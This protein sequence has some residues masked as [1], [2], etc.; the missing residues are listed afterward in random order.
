MTEEVARVFGVP[1]QVIPFKANAA[2][3][4]PEPGPRHHVC[5]MP[6]RA[7]LEILFPRVEGYR[8]AIRNRITVNWDAVP[9]LFLDP[10]KIPP[11]VEMKASLPG[12]S[13]RPSLSGP[14]RLERVDLN[15][16]RQGRREQ[17]LV[18][19]MAGAL[20]KSYVTNGQSEAPAH[21]LFPQIARIVQRY[22]DTKVIPVKPAEKVDAFL[23]PYYGWA[24]ER[25][26]AAIRPDASAGETPEVPIYETSRGPGSTAEVDYWTSKDV[27]E[28]VTSHLNYVVADTKVWEQSAAYV[29][30]TH[31]RVA[32]FVKNAGLGFAIPY[33]H[34]GQPRDYVPDFTV[35]LEGEPRV[36]LIVETKGY[37][38]LAGVKA[39][40]AERWVAAVNADGQYGEWR[41]AMARK[42]SEVR[43]VLDKA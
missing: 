9:P 31:P 12:N 33:L 40:A 30:D 6:G 10:L 39:A 24:V 32:A 37:D 22:F 20:T 27:R 42:V 28:V 8:Q 15:P 16:Y 34:N 5:A 25:L 26:T 38:E 13:G 43:D 17:A 35:R 11:E 23:S 7:A 21:V 29:L 18:F 19:E 1:F 36:H 3:A 2:T 41:Y 4:P 14:G